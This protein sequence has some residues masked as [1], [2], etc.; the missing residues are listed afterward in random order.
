[1]CCA[2][3][4]ATIDLIE[5]EYCAN[6]A[7]VGDYFMRRLQ[8]FADKFPIVG[9]VRGKGLMIGVELVKDR[10]SKEP[11]KKL[12]D[13]LITRAYHNGLILLQCGQSTVRF[14]PPLVIEEA[15]VDEALLLLERSLT[16]VLA[17][18]PLH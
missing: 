2:A 14:M 12:C 1:L 11:A 3:A 9:E 5:R 7:K 6:A 13:A 18:E 16:E 15:D 4:L 8:V 17:S 10:A